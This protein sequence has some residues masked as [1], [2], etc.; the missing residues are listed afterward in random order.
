MS[1]PR[2]K[3]C[4]KQ[5]G[6]T[7]LFIPLSHALTPLICELILFGVSRESQETVKTLKSHPPSSRE[8]PAQDNTHAVVSP[9]LPLSK[10]GHYANTPH[11]SHSFSS[12]HSHTMP[13]K[14]VGAGGGKKRLEPALSKKTLCWRGGR[15]MK[16][17]SCPGCPG[18]RHQLTL[19]QC[20]QH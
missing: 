5:I 1:K 16:E 17:W 12:M 4:N 9:L 2:G 11:Y 20:A 15:V 13:Y 18:L 10:P 14:T 3:F 19:A 8:P 6:Q 7:L